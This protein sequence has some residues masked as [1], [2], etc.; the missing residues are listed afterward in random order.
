[1]ADV[2][3]DKNEEIG[4]ETFGY[5]QELKR[6]LGVPDLVVLGLSMAIPIGLCLI[7]GYIIG[8]A[9][10]M[11]A[12]VY[13][14]AAIGVIFTGN[15]YARMSE[16]FPLAGGA[17]AFVSRGMNRIIGFLIGW[18][19]V[20]MYIVLLPLLYIFCAYALYAIFPNIP[21]FV[22]MVSFIVIN[23]A[24]NYRGIEVTREVLKYILFAQLIIYGWFMVAGLMAIAQGLNGVGFTIAPIYNKANFNLGAIMVGV[25]IAVFNFGGPDVLTTLGEETKGGVKTLGVGVL[26]TF[27]ILGVLFFLLAYV[28]ALVWPNYTTHANADI[29]FYEI[30]AL[31]GGPILKWVFSLAIVIAI[32]GCCVGVQTC[33]SRVLYAMGRDRMF[34]KMFSRIHPKYQSPY[35]G[36]VA[37]GIIALVLSLVFSDKA[38]TMTS[39][40]NFSMLLVWSLVNITTVCYYILKKKSKHYFRDLVCPILG[41]LL[42]GYTFISLKRDAKIA[43]LIWVAIGAVF[44]LYL[45][46]VKKVDISFSSDSGV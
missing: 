45:V 13:V 36:V 30:V 41:L 26:L 25:S 3:I 14:I 18:A 1:M 5:K 15:S 9:K 2:D 38:E 44:M 37:I 33:S 6:A 11:I 20:G 31:A 23:T 40:V 19:M 34:P 43:G 22:W 27:A 8:A 12:L 7:Y 4:V 28:A 17:Y 46:Y 16:A 29:A 42:L 35:I 32:F 39:M 10:G 21:L 24:I